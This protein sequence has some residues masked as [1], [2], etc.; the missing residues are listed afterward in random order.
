MTLGRN[1]TKLWWSQGL[2]N[3][4]DGLVLAAVPLLAV[5]MTRDPLLVAGLTVAQF[6]P[7]LVFTL[8]AGA[9]ADR[10]DRR[11]IIVAGNVVRAAGFALLVLTLAADVRS[12]AVLY[13]AVFL[14]GTAET[15][16]D[17]AALTVP[18]RLVRRSDL[19]RANGRLFATQSA[20]N[21]FIGPTAGA[22]LFA[23]SAVMVFSSTAGLF[24]LGALAAVTLPRMM[25]TASDTSGDKHTPG[26]VVRSIREGWSYFW[27]HR[28]LRR[29]AFISGSINLF[30][31]A[32]GGLLVLLVTGPMGVPASWYGLF[33]AVPAVGAVLGS[34]IAARVVPAIGGGPVTWLAALVP[35]ASYVVLGLSGNVVLSEIVMFLAAVATALNQIVVSTLR[36]AAVPDGLLG[37]VTAG[38]RLIVLGAVP[39]GALLGGALG[40]WL[41]PETT[42]VVCGAGLTAAA[43]VFA[44]RVT[45]RALREAEE[46]RPA[47][48][49]P[50]S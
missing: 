13:V 37:R 21:N 40:R 10:I 28:L 48:T 50:V 15:L 36:Q 18:P 27:N 47:A 25:P 20:I 11:L 7:W 1:F 3:L 14:A 46:A 22:A 35:A 39:V 19:E 6:L 8:P 31:S 44:S 24:A 30:S 49:E 9:L 17:N 32:T 38:Y 16:V 4:G 2:S 23:L 45:T 29:V 26:E 34:L 43:L 41:G 12:I 5:T 33:I 42:F